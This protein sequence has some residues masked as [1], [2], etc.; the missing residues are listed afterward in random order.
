M[1]ILHRTFGGLVPRLVPEA[2][3]E[4]AAQE[5]VNLD[6]RRG[7]LTPVADASSVASLTV[8]SP[9]TIYPWRYTTGG[10]TAGGVS[11]GYAG[12]TNPT[13][14]AALGRGSGFEIR[15]NSQTYQIRPDF[16][17]AATTMA[18]IGDAITFAM[19]QTTG[20]GR[21]WVTFAIP[22][23]SPTDLV[24][25]FFTPG[26]KLVSIGP[27][28]N[29]ALTDLS[30]AAWFNATVTPPT[31]VAGADTETWLAWNTRVNVVPTPV[32]DDFYGRIY[33]TGDGVPKMKYT[34]D[35]SVYTVPLAIETPAI[36]PT[37][38]GTVV[39]APADPGFGTTRPPDGTFA[40]GGWGLA[41][42]ENG[43][44]KTTMY[45]QG[46]VA[47]PAGLASD[48]ILVQPR[49]AL[50]TGL[51]RNSE[52]THAPYVILNHQ[53]IGTPYGNNPLL[54]VG[55]NANVYA[56]ASDGDQGFKVLVEDVAGNPDM[57]WI[58]VTGTIRVAYS[59]ADDGGEGGIPPDVTEEAI[60]PSY[61]VSYVTELGEEGP[62]GPASH[63]APWLATDPVWLTDIPPPVDAAGR[64]I[65]TIRLYRSA[66]GL[67]RW[68]Q[69]IDVAVNEYVD[70][71]PDD[72]S[73][74]GE[75]APEATE[76]APDDLAGL[77]ATP[78]GWFAAFHDRE[79]CLSE[80]WQPH[81]WPAGYRHTVPHAIVAL[82]AVGNDVVVLTEGYP[83]V[84]SGTDPDTVALAI[85]EIDQACVSAA[86]VALLG[87][88]VVYASP[89]G[90]VG[91]YAGQAPVLT[92]GYYRRADWQA[93][94]PT[95][96]VAAA[97]DGRYYACFD[98]TQLY[99]FDF[100]ANAPD[101]LATLVCFAT[102]LYQDPVD[103]ALYAGYGAA[104]ATP[105][106]YQVG[107]AADL[108]RVTWRGREWEFPQPVALGI[109]RIVADSYPV[110]GVGQTD[111]RPLLTLYA[112]GLGVGTWRATSA[113][114]FRIGPLR[115]A[116]RWSLKVT[117]YVEIREIAVATSMRALL[118]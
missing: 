83:I 7:A 116:R 100:T 52:I 54:A 99:V 22:Q 10:T 2:L 87:N 34:K 13:V 45:L 96:L 115:P 30:A 23:A 82:A 61:C 12:Q 59:L 67:F 114:A 11:F 3:P 15:L 48:T 109:V 79:V 50:V 72:D 32:N 41:I 24:A 69:D 44:L 58:T 80:P 104:P 113:L 101:R 89:D 92:Q 111:E 60:Y 95:N 21:I 53:Y 17:A 37:A 29:G 38:T 33:Y 103:D 77:V 107:A 110:P 9:K 102:A 47:S 71:N 112:D 27:H 62:L 6:L 20:D 39:S 40:I 105:A 85:L 98:D 117:S 1:R 108:L 43:S 63:P 65:T 118:A 97:H 35:G 14:W 46:S 93:L 16:P 106:V 25:M 90:L 84:L 26:L 81:S 70:G 56:V 68:L 42:L 51:R 19:R 78:N 88:M 94:G 49:K 75:A 64:R 55:W 36:A 73:L 57:R 74:L 66:G 28:D 31:E 91:F 76:S 86:S 4:T 5:A 8:D 18:Q